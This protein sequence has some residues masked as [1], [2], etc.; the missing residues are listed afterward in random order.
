MQTRPKSLEWCARLIRSLYWLI[1]L[2]WIGFLD[3][4]VDWTDLVHLIGWLNEWIKYIISVDACR[5]REIF[6][7]DQHISW[8]QILWDITPGSTYLMVANFMRYYTRTMISHGWRFH[9]ILHQNHNIL[10]LLISWNVLVYRNHNISIMVAY[11]MTYYTRS[12]IAH[13]CSFHK[14]LHQNHIFSLLQISCNI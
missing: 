2:I 8:L 5:F 1:R 9:E 14:I 7:Q 10:W 11:L 12:T 13:G 3:F 4:W 6:H